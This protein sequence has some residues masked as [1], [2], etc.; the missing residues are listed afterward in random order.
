LEI[1]GSI[2]FLLIETNCAVI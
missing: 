1:I 2:S